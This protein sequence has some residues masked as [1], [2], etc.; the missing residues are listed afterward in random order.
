MNM[1]LTVYI[2][3]DNITITRLVYVSESNTTT[4]FQHIPMFNS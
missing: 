2:A 3:K 4:V 1:I